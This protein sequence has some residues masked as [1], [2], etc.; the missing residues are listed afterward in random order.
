M[1]K[2]KKSD[3]EWK[4]ELTDEQFHVARKKGTEPRIHRGILE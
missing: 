3:T 1:E 2:I 4:K